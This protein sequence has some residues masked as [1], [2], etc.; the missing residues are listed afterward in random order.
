MKLN[1]AKLCLVVA[2]LGAV[3]CNGQSSNSSAK[4][5]VRKTQQLDHARETQPEDH[6]VDAFV[7]PDSEAK[8]SCKSYEELVKAKDQS[9][10]SVSDERYVCFRKSA[11]EFFV[12]AFS[13][14]RFEKI[15]NEK[16]KTV[17]TDPSA[18]LDGTGY[19]DSFKNGVESPQLLPSFFFTGTWRPYNDGI[20]S[21]SAL[22]FEAI[23]FK[24]DPHSALD[25][26]RSQFSV[27]YKYKNT[28]K[29]DVIYK[30]T[31]QRSTGRFIESFH[32]AIGQET[33]SQN[34]GRCVYQK[35][36]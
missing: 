12:I 18:T 21:A 20:F 29:Q 35:A 16:Y 8:L 6:A 30:L 7:C 4:P 24:R 13:A 27:S 3:L 34:T 2:F 5:A 10:P 9:L 1:C 36:E 31:I 26:N 28:T 33:L 23:D 32:N 14:P 15:W 25:I 19:A 11:D 17:M 22:D